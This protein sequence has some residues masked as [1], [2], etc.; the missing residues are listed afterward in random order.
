[1]RVNI[2]KRLR[3]AAQRHHEL[4]G[5]C[6]YSGTCPNLIVLSE[7]FEYSSKLM[8]LVKLE[9]A[10]RAAKLREVCGND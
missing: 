8:K 3:E 10:A 7:E 4:A 2:E 1:M 6:R 9:L 5:R